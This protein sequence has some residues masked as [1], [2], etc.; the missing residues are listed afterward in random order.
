[1]ARMISGFFYVTAIKVVFY[2][3]YVFVEKKITTDIF[4]KF[5]PNF[6]NG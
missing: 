2:N 5:M 1:M 6:V 3:R 4:Y